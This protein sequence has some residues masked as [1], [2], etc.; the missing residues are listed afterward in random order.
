MLI[1]DVEFS[2]VTWHHQS[3]PF[4]HVLTCKIAKTH[5][6]LAGKTSSDDQISQVYI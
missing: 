3:H 6:G 2:A 5:Q 1:V 4:G